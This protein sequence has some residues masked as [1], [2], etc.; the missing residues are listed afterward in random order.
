MKNLLICLVLSFIITIDAFSQQSSRLELSLSADSYFVVRDQFSYFILTESFEAQY[1]Q[2]ATSLI[3]PSLGVRYFI[4]DRFSI[5]SG[6][7]VYDFGHESDR[8]QISNGPSIRSSHRYKAHFLSIPVG[9]DFRFINRKFFSYIGSSIFMDI[10]LGETSDE[11]EFAA[12][13]GLDWRTLNTS[14]GANLGIGY[15][16]SNTFAFTIEPYTTIPLH[17]YMTEEDFFSVQDIKPFRFGLQVG[18]NYKFQ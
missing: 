4:T 5:K 16:F 10:Y 15:Q 17:D 3:F 7:R 1:I 8:L 12:I 13:D 9:V 11:P 2:D 18:I 6:F 14:V